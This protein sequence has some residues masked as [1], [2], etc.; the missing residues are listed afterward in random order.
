MVTSL[1]ISSVDL[2]ILKSSFFH[3]SNLM[4]LIT[5]CKD[6]VFT[7]IGSSIAFYGIILTSTLDM[8]RRWEIPGFQV[9]LLLTI[10]SSDRN[11]NIHKSRI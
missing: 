2:C 8:Q 6:Y 5:S 3:K 1:G 10:G 7:D 9:N 11:W 4:L